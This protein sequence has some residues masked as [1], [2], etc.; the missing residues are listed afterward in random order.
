MARKLTKEEQDALKAAIL[1]VKP[2]LQRVW[3]ARP[4]SVEEGRAADALI[5][6]FQELA[7]KMEGGE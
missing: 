6:A 2:A 7:D 3:S 1:K 5:D 4:G